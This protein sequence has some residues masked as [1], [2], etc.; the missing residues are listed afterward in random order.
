MR[1]KHKQI[2]RKIDRNNIIHILSLSSRNLSCKMQHYKKFSRKELYPYYIV[3]YKQF[4]VHLF[5]IHQVLI[6]SYSFF[7]YESDSS[8]NM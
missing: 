4:H 2:L 1:P 7:R 5:C 3:H 8:F 6:I